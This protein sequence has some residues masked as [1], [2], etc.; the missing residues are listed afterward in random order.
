[1]ANDEAKEEGF[2]SSARFE[3][4]AAMLNIVGTHQFTTVCVW[5]RIEFDHEAVDFEIQS[6][7]VGFMCPT[8]KAKISGQLNVLDSGLSMNFHL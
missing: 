3:S 8:C 6:D 1:M 7:S 4:E 2:N 5:C